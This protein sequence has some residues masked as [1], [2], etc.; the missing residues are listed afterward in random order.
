M[1]VPVVH[2]PLGGRGAGRGGHR[3]MDRRGVTRPPGRRPPAGSSRGRSPRPPARPGRGR[4][5]AA[6]SPGRTAEAGEVRTGRH[7]PAPGEG[8]RSGR[9]G[10]ARRR[11]CHRRRPPPRRTR[12]P[13]PLVEPFRQAEDARP[14]RPAEGAPARGDTCGAPARPPQPRSGRPV[15]RSDRPPSRCRRLPRTPLPPVRGDPAPRCLAGPGTA[16]R[17]RRSLPGRRAV[18]W[19][20]GV[21]GPVA[22]AGAVPAVV[23]PAERRP[24]AAGLMAGA[25]VTRTGARWPATDQEN[26]PAVPPPPVATPP[27]GLGVPKGGV[28]C[29]H[30]APGGG[31]VP[32]TR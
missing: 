17:G 2:P 26:A 1:R 10:R 22:A 25:P 30:V 9:T 16:A 6:R 11:P 19:V 32:S 4:R 23:E 28:S 3:R 27:L 8:R 7:G 21:R 31:R 24:P 18:A 12:A 5:A 14:P 29:S 13:G 15:P 20:V